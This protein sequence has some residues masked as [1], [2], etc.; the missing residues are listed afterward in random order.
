MQQDECIRLEN[1]ANDY[2]HT[3][4]VS[5]IDYINNLTWVIHSSQGFLHQR[6][7]NPDNIDS[8]IVIQEINACLTQWLVDIQNYQQQLHE[9]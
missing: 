6:S 1:E 4:P 8:P 5:N 2:R 3:H 9:L 7:L